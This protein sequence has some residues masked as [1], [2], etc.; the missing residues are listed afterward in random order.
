MW[1]RMFRTVECMHQDG[2]AVECVHQDVVTMGCV[3]GCLELRSVRIGM[4]R[5]VKCVHWDA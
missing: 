3:S 2:K 4:F 1:F 5:A